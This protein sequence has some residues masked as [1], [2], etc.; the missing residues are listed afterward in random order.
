MLIYGSIAN[1]IMPFFTSDAYVYGTK[2]FKI[3]VVMT[4]WLSGLVTAIIGH[5]A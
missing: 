4:M 3:T 5:W 2:T 1:I